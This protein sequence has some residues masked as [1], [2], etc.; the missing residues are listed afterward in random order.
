MPLRAG[1]LRPSQAV[2]QFG[3]G[4]LVDLP[5]LSMVI[6]GA[7]EW[8]LSQSKKLDEPRLARRLHVEVFREPPYFVAKQGTGGIPGP[9]C[10][11]GVE[12]PP[13][14]TIRR[15]GDPRAPRCVRSD[16]RR[17]PPPRIDRHPPSRSAEIAP[18]A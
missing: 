6:A 12:R 8:N 14:A 17:P 3:P 4:S 16:G 13:M 15:P 5:T 9:C 11:P 10:P 2:T 18:N 7:N 1:K